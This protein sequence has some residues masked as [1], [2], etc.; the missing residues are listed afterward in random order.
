MAGW[1]RSPGHDA[2]LLMPAATRF[3]IAIAKNSNAQY[4]VYWA[5]EM[6]SEPPPRTPGEGSFLSLSGA[7]TQTRGREASQGEI[8]VRF[9][10]LDSAPS[11]PDNPMAGLGCRSILPNGVSMSSRNITAAIAAVVVLILLIAL[12]GYPVMIWLALL[13]TWAILAFIVVLSAGDMLQK[14]P[15]SSGA[16]QEKSGTSAKA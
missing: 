16:P 11:V 8:R 5:M 6:A 9:R 10:A 12:I 14:K 7:A 13:A 4:G 1:P 3:G 15:V 2:N